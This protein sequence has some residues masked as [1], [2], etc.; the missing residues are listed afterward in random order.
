M[1]ITLSVP[2]EAPNITRYMWTLNSGKVA[3]M[4]YHVWEE[5]DFVTQGS[6]ARIWRATSPQSPV[7]IASATH[8]MHPMAQY[9]NVGRLTFRMMSAPCLSSTLLYSPQARNCMHTPEVIAG[10]SLHSAV[11]GTHSQAPHPPWQAPTTL[12][13]HPS[14]A[15]PTCTHPGH[16]SSV[17]QG[18][19]A[20]T[21]AAAASRSEKRGCSCTHTHGDAVETE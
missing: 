14:S 12:W 18:Q 8:L 15:P 11:S 5:A 16:P 20:T 7:M 21:S 2:K 19:R 1:Y 3:V 6:S 17:S 10:G 13:S 4:K 9:A